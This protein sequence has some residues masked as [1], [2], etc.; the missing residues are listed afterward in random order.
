VSLS[1]TGAVK[2]FAGRERRVFKKVNASVM[3]Y[4]VGHCWAFR[5][6]GG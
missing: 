4:D 5:K 6:G 1:G 2:I 3:R